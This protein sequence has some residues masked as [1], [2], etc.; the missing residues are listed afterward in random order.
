M[1]SKYIKITNLKDLSNFILEASKVEGDVL[2][3][4]GKFCVDG[5]SLMGMMSIDISNGCRIDYPENEK[6]FEEYLKKFE[7]N[8]T[9]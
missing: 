9:F 1:K 6:D 5:K 8:L 2:V 7:L 4:R 3:H